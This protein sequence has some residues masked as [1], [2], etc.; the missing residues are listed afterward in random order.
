MLDAG[1]KTADHS[2]IL[3]F[4]KKVHD[5]LLRHPADFLG[6]VRVR[7]QAVRKI[8]LNDSQYFSFFF[9]KGT[10]HEFLRSS[11]VN[12]EAAPESRRRL[13]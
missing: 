8:R 5:C 4:P 10:S 7:R 6:N 2:F 13:R 12:G 3:Q 11:R 1:T 9:G